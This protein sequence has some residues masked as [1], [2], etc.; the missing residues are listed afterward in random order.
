MASIAMLDSQLAVYWYLKTYFSSSDPTPRYS[1]DF[2]LASNL[3]FFLAF[4][5]TYVLTFYLRFAKVVATFK[6][7]LPI[8]SPFSSTNPFQ[9]VG[10]WLPFRF[11]GKHKRVSVRLTLWLYFSHRKCSW[12]S[13]EPEELL[14]KLGIFHELLPFD[15]SARWL[16]AAGHI[17]VHKLGFSHVS[18]LP[19]SSFRPQRVDK[20]HLLYTT[21]VSKP[22]YFLPPQ[23]EQ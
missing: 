14:A 23:E 10:S 4:D 19:P 18:K 16:V 15:D 7:S 3:T 5:L 9:C 1:F 6:W 11:G 2:Y 21:E 20:Q 17:D 8:S 22:E 13:C 12:R